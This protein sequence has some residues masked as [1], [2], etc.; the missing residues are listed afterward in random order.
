MGRIYAQGM[1]DAATEGLISWKGA[2]YAHLS[3]NFYPPLPQNV[4]ESTVKTIEQFNAGEIED[5]ALA[6]G[7]Y[8][9]TLEAV[10]HYHGAFI[11]RDDANDSYEPFMAD[12]GDDE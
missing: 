1:A 10:Y 9:R 5:D 12:R 2:F 3:T 8:L 7:C 11:T 4:K 6:D